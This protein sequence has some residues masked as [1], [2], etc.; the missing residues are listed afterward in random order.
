MVVSDDCSFAFESSRC[1]LE[2]SWVVE[3][4]LES[5]GLIEGEM[6]GSSRGFCSRSFVSLMEM[7]IFSRSTGVMCFS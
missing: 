6:M 7:T 4:D 1:N 2:K 3:V 5:C